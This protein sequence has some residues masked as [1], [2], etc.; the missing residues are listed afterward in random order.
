VLRC[1]ELKASMAKLPQR[2]IPL[3][4]A[5]ALS[6]AFAADI[7]G[8]VV[9]IT[10]GD[11]ITVFHEG[12]RIIVRLQGIDSPESGQAFG[13][14]AKQFTSSLACGQDASDISRIS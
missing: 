14:R 9:G 7:Q 13:T 6:A 4:I 1:F 5:V 2:L 10:D 12:R 8:K 3:L 11:T